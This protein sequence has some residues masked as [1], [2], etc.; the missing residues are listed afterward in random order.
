MAEAI[1]RVIAFE[2]HGVAINA[3]ALPSSSAGADVIE[4]ISE[5][6]VPSVLA[7]HVEA[8]GVDPDMAETIRRMRHQHVAAGLKLELDTSAVSAMLTAMSVDH[9]VVKGAA[10]SAMTGFAPSYRGAG[11]IDLWVRPADLARA[12]RAL[13]DSGWGRYRSTLPQPSDG[14]RWRLLVAVG[15][16][17]PQQAVAMSPIDLHWRLTQFRGE[18]IPTFDE[19]YRRSVTVPALGAGVRTLC[20][21]DALV[22]LAQHGRKDVWPTLRHVIDVIRVVDR[23][24][25]DEVIDMATR[26]PNVALALAVARSI[27]ARLAPDWTPRAR[28]RELAAEAWQSCLSLRNTLA[29]RQQTSGSQA[30]A[31]R[32]QYEWWQFRSGPTWTYRASRTYRLALPLHVLVRPTGQ[33]TGQAADR[34]DDS[35]GSLAAHG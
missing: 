20:P 24:D 22:H 4:A 12:E 30:F 21:S 6:R 7:S 2:R 34:Q 33:S 32:A 3:L 26:I 35:S 10:L 17:L 27:D 29:E 23:C 15:N 25:R 5:H 11:D 18:C 13:H 19:A 9:L 14:W 31:V 1:A 8:L 28:T 16:E